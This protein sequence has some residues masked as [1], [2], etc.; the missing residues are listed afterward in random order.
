MILRGHK[1][2]NNISKHINANV[3]KNDRTCACNRLSFHLLYVNE[4]AKKMVVFV[5]KR[6]AVREAENGGTQYARPK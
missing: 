2:G 6:Y 4:N 1:L 5:V 3:C